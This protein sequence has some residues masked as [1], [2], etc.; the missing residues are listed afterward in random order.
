MYSGMNPTFKIGQ[1][2]MY[3]TKETCMYVAKKAKDLGYDVVYGVDELRMGY[4]FEIVDP[5]VRDN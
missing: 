3:I 5:F 1:R 4:Y 2:Y